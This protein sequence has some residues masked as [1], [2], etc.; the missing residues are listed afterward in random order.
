MEILNKNDVIVLGSIFR[1]EGNDH[2]K[3][4]HAA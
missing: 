3:Q 4:G 1:K 2:A